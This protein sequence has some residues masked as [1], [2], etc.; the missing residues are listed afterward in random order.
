MSMSYNVEGCEQCDVGEGFVSAVCICKTVEEYIHGDGVFTGKVF[1][2]EVFTGG[3]FTV[4]SG[5]LRLSSVAVSAVGVPAGH[6]D[7][8]GCSNISTMMSQ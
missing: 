6:L 8:I 4:R 2:G 7:S 1:T 3:L 5:V